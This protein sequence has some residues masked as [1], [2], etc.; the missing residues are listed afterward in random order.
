M[1]NQNIPGII[2]AFFAYL[3][4]QVTLV[5]NM[6]LFNVAFCYVYVA[7]ILLLPFDTGRV[8][9]LALGFICGILVDIFYN[10]LGIH[11]F[12][13]VL[14]AFI[15]PLWTN[16]IPPRGGYELGM[17]P[18]IKIMGFSWFLTYSLPLIFIH[19][20]FIF[21]IEVGGWHLFGFTFVKVIFSTIL[22]FIMVVIL[23]YLFYQRRRS[24]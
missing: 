7:I 11:A 15:K 22:T 4:L 9:L 10:T 1:N 19:H 6:V 18:S 3:I 8:L 20:L 2:I 16:A 23:Q 14:L 12:A 13:C 17:A 5:Q 24:I 21:F